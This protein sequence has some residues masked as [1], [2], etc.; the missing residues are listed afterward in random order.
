MTESELF[1]DLCSQGLMYSKTRKIWTSPFLEWF[2]KDLTC[3]YNWDTLGHS[4]ESCEQFKKHMWSLLDA[5]RI[6]IQG[7]VIEKGNYEEVVKGTS[8]AEDTKRWG[9]KRDDQKL[10]EKNLEL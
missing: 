2:Q 1:K 7:P 8:K 5:G 3:I 9:S 4:I 6:N 10:V